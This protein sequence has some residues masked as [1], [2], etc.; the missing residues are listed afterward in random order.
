MDGG[1]RAVK[2]SRVFGVLDKVYAEGTHIMIPWFEWPVLYDVRAKPRNIPSLT[3]SKG[4]RFSSPLLSSLRI[5][6]NLLFN[7]LMNSDLQMVNI[8]L[9]V[10]SRPEVEKLPHI[11]RTLGTDFD[12]RVLPSIVNEV[13]KSVVAQFNAGQLITQRDRVFSPF[14]FPFPSLFLSTLFNN[15][16]QNFKVSKLIRERLVERAQ[17]FDI[18]VE[19][20]AIV[21]LFLRFYALLKN[22]N[23]SWS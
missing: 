11:F 12:E 19:D 2:F 21:R 1:H 3:G 23:N 7:L 16:F 13:L 6:R 9:R 18:I 4:P 10:L 14:P 17:Q 5:A 22:K 20:V 8:T 15:S